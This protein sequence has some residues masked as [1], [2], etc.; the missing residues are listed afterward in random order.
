MPDIT[1][2][3]ETIPTSLYKENQHYAPKPQNAVSVR[4]IEELTG[5]C[6]FTHAN[7]VHL[8]KFAF[9]SGVVEDIS[10][11]TNVANI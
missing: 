3:R 11:V 4:K 8:G 9:L 5:V 2:L 7:Y 1:H 10:T 6:A